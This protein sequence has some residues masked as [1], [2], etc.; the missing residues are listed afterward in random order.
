MDASKKILFVED[1]ANLLNSMSYILEKEGF[2]VI[3]ASS[4]EEA[5]RIAVTARPQIVL[6]DLRLPGIDGFEVAKNLRQRRELTDLCIIMLTASD[7]EE[8]IVR[9]LDDYADDY[10]IK[11]VR[12]RVL[13]ARIK[14]VTRRKLVTPNLP[15]GMMQING[16]EIDQHAF[17]VKVDG[18]RLDLTKSEFLILHHLAAH[19]NRVFTRDQLI[20]RIRGHNYAITERSIDYQI[21]CLRKKLG[22]FA[23]RIDTVRGVGYKFKES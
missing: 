9:A 8:D 13:L 21:F 10:V 23:D 12:P 19:P 1:E 18:T 11:P 15:S 3:P 16:L 14:A 22:K 2:S 20:S 7:A 5:L 6:L 17:E 4:G